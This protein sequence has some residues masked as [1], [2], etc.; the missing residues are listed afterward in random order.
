[1]LKTLLPDL[2]RK[3]HIRTTLL[4]IS[5]LDSFLEINDGIS[6]DEV[7][8][9]IYKKALRE[10]EITCPLI[11]EMPVN[12]AQLCTCY[13]RPGW[14]EIK[15]NFTLFLDCMISEHQIIL[16][17]T[18]LP[19]W[20]VGDVGV[21]TNLN[22]YYGGAST[23]LPSAYTSFTDY[24]A[25]YVYIGDLGMMWGT[26]NTMLSNIYIKGTVARPIVPD[27]TKDKNFN[28]ASE[29]GAIYW[30]VVETGGARGNY[31]MDLVMVHVLDYIRQLKAAL[32]LPNMSIDILAN[33]DAAYQELRSRCDQFALQSGWYGELLY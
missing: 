30:M 19:S 21:T 10:F 20:R 23:P 16:L 33:V 17:P 28:S 25:P 11:L 3:V 31:F 26:G 5:G 1:M 8:L 29:R 9:E 7:L 27:F 14:A 12:S 24:Q 13:G 4:G 32:T 6:G 18:S 2:T 15:P 22:N